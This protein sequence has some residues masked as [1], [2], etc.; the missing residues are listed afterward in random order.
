MGEDMEQQVKE[1]ESLAELLEDLDREGITGYA[2]K[3]LVDQFMMM[4]ARVLRKPYTPSFALTPLCNLDCKMCYVRKSKTEMDAEGRML[5]CD[6]W[7]SIADEAVEAGTLFLLLTGGEPLLYPEF[8]RLYSALAQKGLILSVN[9]NVHFL[10]N[11]GKSHRIFVT[12]IDIFRS[13]IAH[14]LPG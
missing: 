9:T 13:C 3:R 4:R 7:L 8:R 2:R 5:S 1:F 11:L 12:G 6:E 10:G 14:S